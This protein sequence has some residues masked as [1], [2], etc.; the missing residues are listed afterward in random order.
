MTQYVDTFHDSAL[1][2]LDLG[3]EVFWQYS[4][5]GAAM[6]RSWWEVSWLSSIYIP[7]YGL[8]GPSCGKK[9]AMVVNVLFC[10]GIRIDVSARIRFP[11][12]CLHSA[13]YPV[14]I[15]WLIGKNRVRGRQL[16][17]YST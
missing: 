1:R 7:Q 12:S 9:C 14:K 10:D 5:G 17:M 8:V 15:I 11:F 16:K 4:P 6:G 2:V 3:L 13:E